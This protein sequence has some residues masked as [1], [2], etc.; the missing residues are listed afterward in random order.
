MK[1]FRMYCDIIDDEKIAAISD[2]AFKVFVFLMSICTQNDHLDGRIPDEKILSWRFRMKEI[3]IEKSLSELMDQGIISRHEGAIII[4]NWRKRQFKSDD[5]NARVERFRTNEKKKIVTLHETLHETPQ[6]RTDTEQIQKQIQKREK[7]IDVF[8][9]HLLSVLKI[10]M[11][12]KGKTEDLLKSFGLDSMIYAVDRMKLYFDE[13]KKN[14]WTKYVIGKH[15][16][17]LYEKIE[18]FSSDENL[19]NKIKDTERANDKKE[20]VDGR[21][22]SNDFSSDE[23]LMRRQREAKDV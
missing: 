23:E 7:D 2:R 14:R 12:D 5:I 3:K 1:W 9:K 13:V 6:N 4:T 10:P 20:K 22:V 17:N 8:S 18:Y 19:Y 15:W 16:R 11:S 21:T